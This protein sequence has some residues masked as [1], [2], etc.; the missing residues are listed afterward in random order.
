VRIG[1][2]DPGPL[3]AITD[4]GGV[5]VGHITVWRA[6]PGGRGIARTGA[7]AIVPAPADSLYREPVPTGAAV[8]NGAGEMT[9]YITVSEWGRIETP[10]YLTSTM[11]VGRVYDG[12]VAAAVAADPAVGDEEVVIPVVAECDDSWLSDSAVVQVEAEDAS[13]AGAYTGAVALGAAAPFVEAGT[14][15][16]FATTGFVVG[17][18]DQVSHTLELWVKPESA[19]Q[20]PA[21]RHRLSRQPRRGR[22]G[23]RHRPA[24]QAGGRHRRQQREHQDHAPE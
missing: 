10:V 7:P 20:G 22:L 23:G 5:Q 3:N 2:L 18:V 1:A 15:A 24:A 8:L 14:A 4:V 19:R 11:A 21:G 12:T 17:D 16:A 13:R 9:G 6:E